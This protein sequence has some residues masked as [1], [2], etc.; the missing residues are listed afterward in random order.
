[1]HSGA[2]E[3]GHSSI[4]SKIQ[5]VTVVTLRNPMLLI[6]PALETGIVLHQCEQVMPKNA[7]VVA[8]QSKSVHTK[9][10]VQDQFRKSSMQKE[11]ALLV[12]SVVPRRALNANVRKDHCAE[13]LRKYITV[14]LVS[15]TLHAFRMHNEIKFL[16]LDLKQ[17]CTRFLGCL[18][19]TPIT[20]SF[21]RSLQVKTLAGCGLPA[22]NILASA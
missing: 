8:T 4:E 14:S 6:Q 9:W 10:C 5:R 7:D 16:G 17:I 21:H 22:A 20:A 18:L 2:V 12:F 15:G 1:M 11:V 13:A 3:G 19:V